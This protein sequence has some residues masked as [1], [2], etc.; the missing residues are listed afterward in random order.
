MSRLIFSPL[1]ASRDACNMGALILSESHSR[2][3]FQ[4]MCITGRFA[5]SFLEE[6]GLGA[7]G[8]R[9]PGEFPR[10]R[11][12]PLSRRATSGGL[13]LALTRSKFYFFK[14]GDRRE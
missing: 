7:P 12:R 5:Q 3:G 9:L 2:S 11:G 10:S 14:W 1:S 6:S 4:E 8:I 13:R